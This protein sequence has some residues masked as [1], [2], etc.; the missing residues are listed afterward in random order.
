MT[1]IFMVVEPGSVSVRPSGP[2]TANVWLSLAGCEFPMRGWN[3]FA[4]VILGWW[5]TAL[6]RLLRNVSTR[7]TVNFMD[8][9]YSVEVSRTPS[10]MLHL[11][12]LEGSTRNREMATG[13]V[14]ANPFVLGLISQSRGVLDA[15]RRQGWWSNDAQTLESALAALEQESS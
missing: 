8:G 9:P 12:A 10:G 6:L 7:E 13:E 15:C 1:D 5:A 14:E 3:D 11:R 2:A 4:V